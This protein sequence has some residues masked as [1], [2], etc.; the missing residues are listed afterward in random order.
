MMESILVDKV[1]KGIGDTG[2]F[3]NVMDALGY[4]QPKFQEGFDLANAIQNMDLV[5]LL[6]SNFTQNKIIVEFTL[7][8]KKRYNEIL[9]HQ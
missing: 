2:G 6:Y 4:D 3:G 8:G 9:T 7:L 5:K 1:I